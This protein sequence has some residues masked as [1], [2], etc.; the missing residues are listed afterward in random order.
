MFRLK[1]L[2]P[3][4]YKFHIEAKLKEDRK[5]YKKLYSHIKKNA[6]IQSK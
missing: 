2:D 1:D 6:K 4:A 5:K 3:E